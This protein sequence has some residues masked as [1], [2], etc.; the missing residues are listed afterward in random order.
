MVAPKGIYAP[1]SL[2]C[3]SRSGK[4][5]KLRPMMSNRVSVASGIGSSKKIFGKENH[6]SKIDALTSSVAK[7]IA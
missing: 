3:A 1:Y 7:E 4:R 6:L 2:P 5:F